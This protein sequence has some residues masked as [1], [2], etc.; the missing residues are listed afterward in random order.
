MRWAVPWGGAYRVFETSPEICRVS[1][2]EGA[3][4][5]QRST[6]VADKTHVGDI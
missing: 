2:K 4:H 1:L 6:V 3:V 5:R